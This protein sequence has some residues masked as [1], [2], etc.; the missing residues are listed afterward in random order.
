MRW[1]PGITDLMDMSLNKLQKVVKDREACHPR[2]RHES[3]ATEQLQHGLHPCVTAQPAAG[4]VYTQQL[5]LLLRCPVPRFPRPLPAA[6]PCITRLYHVSVSIL[7]YP[8]VCC[9][10]KILYVSEIM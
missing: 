2:G 3:D 4:L 9:I 6:I 8:L 10:S 1:L 5:L 7:F